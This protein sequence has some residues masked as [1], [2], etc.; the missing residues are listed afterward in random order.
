MVYKIPSDEEV[1][2]AIQRVI[3]KHHTINS[4][5]RLKNLVEDELQTL[6]KKFRV[7]GLRIRKLVLKSKYFHLEIHYKNPPEEQDTKKS[8]KKKDGAAKSGNEKKAKKPSTK[9]KTKARTT[10]RACPVCASKVKKIKN[11][12]LR[13]GSIIAGYK[14]TGCSYHTS[15]PVRIPARYTFSIRRL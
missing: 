3:S 12:T 10:L 15:L 13:G 4:Q 7:S 5:H 2:T 14:C 6:D 9:S 1:V 8:K 11:R